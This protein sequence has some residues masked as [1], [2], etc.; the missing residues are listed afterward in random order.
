MKRDNRLSSVLHAILHLAESTTP[1]TSEALAAC[2]RTNPVVVRRIMAGL[3]EAG[4][5]TAAR[6]HG[7]GWALARPLSD[8]SLS[9]VHAALGNPDLFGFG[10]SREPS[11]CPLQ[12]AVDAALEAERRAAEVHLLDRM[13]HIRLS[14][15]AA[16]F[17]R[18]LAAN[19]KETHHDT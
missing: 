2:M 4:I 18:R 12:Q 13:K 9:D 7:G 10:G 6:G 5:V 14:D 17:E 8:T 16:D 3:R 1:M 15:L 19:G 11:A